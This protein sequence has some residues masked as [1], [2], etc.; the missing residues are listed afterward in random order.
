MGTVPPTV[1]RSLRN[2]WVKGLRWILPFR[3]A[4]ARDEQSRGKRLR[5]GVAPS[6]ELGD[7]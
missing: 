3:I 1:K 7:Q 2:A 4:R 6:V 5:D